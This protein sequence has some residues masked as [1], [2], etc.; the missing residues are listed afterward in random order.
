MPG[1]GSRGGRYQRSPNGARVGG[2]VK[3]F[4]GVGALLL[5]SRVF[6]RPGSPCVRRVSAIDRAQRATCPLL[7]NAHTLCN[8]RHHYIL[9]HH[10]ERDG[11]GG[12]AA[13][14]R[15]EIERPDGG[16]RRRQAA[17]RTRAT[18]WPS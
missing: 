17:R 14:D 2:V 3:I 13:G 9:I 1:R 18:F 10:S 15:A 6:G 7:H 12:R 4:A 16:R 11:E 5:W 8:P